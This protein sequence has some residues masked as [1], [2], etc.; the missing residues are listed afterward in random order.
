MIIKGVFLLVSV[1]ILALTFSVGGWAKG[2]GRGEGKRPEGY[3]GA[4]G[5]RE[6]M[7]SPEIIN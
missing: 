3:S 4:A 2:G 1:L 6:E 7:I 5:R